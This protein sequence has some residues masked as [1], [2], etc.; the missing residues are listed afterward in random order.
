MNTNIYVDSGFFSDSLRLTGQV[1]WS[2][3]SGEHYASGI[4]D[5]SD[6]SPL[7]I[8]LPFVTDHKDKVIFYAYDEN[9]EAVVLSSVKTTKLLNIDID[10]DFFADHLETVSLVRWVIFSD[11][12]TFRGSF[13]LSEGAPSSLT[14][15][16]T[17][18]NKAKAF[19]YAIEDDGSFE[20]IERTK[21]SVTDDGKVAEIGH[22]ETPAP[23]PAPSQP[24]PSEP[25]APVAPQPAPREPIVHEYT[26]TETEDGFG[27]INIQDFIVGVDTIALPR[28][29][30]DD[31]D[32]HGSDVLF[33]M[34]NGDAV[35]IEFR[36]SIVLPEDRRIDGVIELGILAPA[37]QPEPEA[38]ASRP[39]GSITATPEP[40]SS[41]DE[42]ALAVEAAE[43]IADGK[44]VASVS[45]S[46]F[47]SQTPSIIVTAVDRDDSNTITEVSANAIYEGYAGNDVITVGDFFNF[48]AGGYGDDILNLGDGI[49]TVAYYFE[50]Q[51]DAAIKATDGGDVINNFE[52]GTD[53]LGLA[54]V[55]SDTPITSLAEFVEFFKS[56]LD[57]A[58][59]SAKV[60]SHF[61]G[62]DFVGISFVFNSAGTID[63]SPTD[64]QSGRVLR[65]NFKS[66]VASSDFDSDDF[67]EGSSLTSAGLD[68][69]DDW[70][71][72]DNFRVFDQQSFSDDLGA[73]FA[74]NDQTITYDTQGVDIF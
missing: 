27:Y 67:G 2:I 49:D 46:A 58:P 36:D 74:D 70:F 39:E 66:P 44:V 59:N 51:S 38:P 43:V 50:S 53:R 32:L 18:V 6:E 56:Q 62:D 41:E 14:V 28:D 8:T 13:D 52:L 31:A 29:Q 19:F 23:Q 48:V 35:H 71:G 11:E 9:T 24:A 55:A 33:V 16:D 72:A 21:L 26:P 42:A 47:F 68:K 10:S 7:Y 17:P 20:L 64:E 65:I 57:D 30:I 22:D 63:G 54:D 5:L 73:A 1:R 45:V 37:P 3:Q 4:F 12:N 34:T 25:E 40:L 61:D 15:L 60:I 69:I